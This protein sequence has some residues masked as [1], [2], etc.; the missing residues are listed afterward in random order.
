MKVFRVDD[1]GIYEGLVRH[2]RFKPVKHQLCYRVF[3]F[4][5]D[6]DQ[7]DNLDSDLRWFSRNR[8]NVFS[9]YDRDHGSGKPGNI[10]DWVRIH[11][12]E[13]G[14]STAGKILL[15]FYPRILGYA[16]NPI[17]VYYCYDENNRLIAT[18]Y[19]VRNTFGGRHGYLIPVTDNAKLIHQKAEKL[20]H[21]SPFVDMDMG[22][23]FILSPPGEVISVTVKVNDGGG[24]LLNANFSGKRTPF[25]NRSLKRLFFRYPMMTIKVVAGIH[26]EAVKLLAKGLRLKEGNPDPKMPVT[27]VR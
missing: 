4:L 26:W 27:L 7:L 3:S 10:A 25:T 11:L 14:L 22:Y 21:V 17:T 18:L 24:P 8:F 23:H 19:A 20:L 13:A 9:F 16:F 12:R 15:L 5:V 2:H 1:H 6:I